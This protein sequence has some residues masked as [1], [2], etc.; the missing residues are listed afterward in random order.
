MEKRFEEGK[1][2]AVERYIKV[3]LENSKYPKDFEK[4]MKLNIKRM[5]RY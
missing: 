1:Q 5:K 2:D 3:V 4:I